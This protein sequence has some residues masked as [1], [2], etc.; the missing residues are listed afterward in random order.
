M[1]TSIVALVAAATLTATAAH[2]QAPSKRILGDWMTAGDSARVR[3]AP[4]RSNPAT[5]CGH[6]VA[7]K[8]GLQDERDVQNSNPSLRGRR[9][10]GMPFIT[11]FKP[12]GSNR[13]SGGKIY[14]P[15]NGKTYSAKMALNGNGTLT[16]SGC[17]VMVLCQG[18]TWTRAR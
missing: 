17:V 1:K 3:V 4:C 16:V 12:A 2:A 6:F 9:L 8:G 11:G 7:L 10:I 13:W 14:N 15:K 18:E 5:I